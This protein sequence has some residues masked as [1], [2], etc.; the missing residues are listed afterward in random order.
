[1]PAPHE[2]AQPYRQPD[3]HDRG[4]AYRPAPYDQPDPYDQ[5]Q[6]DRP[7]QYDQPQR[8]DE[9]EAG[10]R[11]AARHD[12][13][14]VAA[15]PEDSWLQLD[16]EPASGGRRERVPEEPTAFRRRKGGPVGKIVVLSVVAVLCLALLGGGA[17]FLWG[18]KQLGGSGEEYF[19][20]LTVT[21]L[22][23]KAKQ[24]GFQCYPGSR[25]AQCDKEI[26]GAD[27]GITV[28]FT[29]EEQV[30]KL[31]ASGGTAAYT[32]DAAKPEDLKDFFE[33]AAQLPLDG[34]GDVA[35]AKTWSVEHIAKSG[36]QT[37]GGVRYQSAGDQPLLTMTPA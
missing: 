9:P 27:L 13:E 34:Q 12:T 11:R 37:I 16:E 28:H 25:I 6:Y 2:P 20:S 8:Y 29:G 10:P 30:T 33:W 19:P 3:E 31:E 32:N 18:G 23:S 35:T 1:V 5:P 15:E 7:G 36:E 4:Q 24:N 26:K 17:Y 21:E 14:S 22:I